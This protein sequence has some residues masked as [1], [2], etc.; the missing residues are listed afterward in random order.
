MNYSSLLLTCPKGMLWKIFYS[1]E[2]LMEAW[3]S[4]ICW[5]SEIINPMKHLYWEN[6]HW[7][8]FDQCN[9]LL[10]AADTF[11]TTVKIQKLIC[12]IPL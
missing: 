10:S 2:S 5:N 6:R 11:G 8:V 7:T 4:D 12:I 9:S 3:E 1:S